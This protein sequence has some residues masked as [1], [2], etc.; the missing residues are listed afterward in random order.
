[1]TRKV[2]GSLD[3][4]GLVGGMSLLSCGGWGGKDSLKG[5]VFHDLEIEGWTP[6][7]YFRERGQGGSKKQQTLGLYRKGIQGMA[8][9]E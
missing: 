8:W 4:R 7:N 2:I 5:P 6:L 3:R 9:G 1:V